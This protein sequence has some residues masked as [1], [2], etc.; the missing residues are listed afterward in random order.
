MKL[1]A[2]PRGFLLSDGFYSVQSRPDPEG[3]QLSP[4]EVHA[5]HQE[6]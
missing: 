5:V 6:G 3:G 2:G 4:E 1:L